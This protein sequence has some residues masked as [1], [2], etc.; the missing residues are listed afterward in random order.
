MAHTNSSAAT[1]ITAALRRAGTALPEKISASIAALAPVADAV[2][3]N[4]SADLVDAYANAIL[5]GKDP[6]AD[7]AVLAALT[8]QVLSAAVGWDTLLRDWQDEQVGHILRDHADALASS[9]RAQVAEAGGILAEAAQVLAPDADLPSQADRCLRGGERMSNAWRAATD[10]TIK[11][12]ALS[13]SFRVLAGAVRPHAVAVA[14]SGILVRAS[15]VSAQKLALLPPSIGT[16]ELA[17]HEGQEITGVTFDSLADAYD[18][19]E[20]ERRAA[21]E[22]FERARRH[23][24]NPA[25]TR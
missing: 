24:Y 21:D 20:A 5:A 12:D 13:E 11:V 9:W 4:V 7:K 8:R 23:R 25:S 2:P 22:A 10:A 1:L 15:G 19:L 3:K 18:R 17:A 6:Y 16:W 14:G